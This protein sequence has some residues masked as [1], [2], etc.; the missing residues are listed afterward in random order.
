[1]H[2]LKYLPLLIPFLLTA[3]V[4]QAGSAENKERTARMSCLS[5]DYA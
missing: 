4:A 3:Q 1:M 2:S 5:G